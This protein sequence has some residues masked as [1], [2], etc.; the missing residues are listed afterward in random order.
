[1]TSFASLPSQ[2]ATQQETASN[3]ADD[4]PGEN[5]GAALVTNAVADDFL[6]DSAHD[7]LLAHTA[8]DSTADDA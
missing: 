7:I 1:V 4:G 8:H 3:V 6:A 5:L 2:Q